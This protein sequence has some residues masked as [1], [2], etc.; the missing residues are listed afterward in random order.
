ME[1]IETKMIFN[2]SSYTSYRNGNT[3]TEVLVEKHKNDF[4]ISLFI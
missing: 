2:L 4:K 3:F 1:R